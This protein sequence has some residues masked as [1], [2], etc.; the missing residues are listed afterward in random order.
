MFSPVV[1]ESLWNI[2]N[3]VHSSHNS[4]EH[5]NLCPLPV[6]SRGIFEVMSSHGANIIVGSLVEHLCI[7]PPTYGEKCCSE[8]LWNI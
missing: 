3:N 1:L 5:L 7:C 4:E 6:E 2:Y 8:F